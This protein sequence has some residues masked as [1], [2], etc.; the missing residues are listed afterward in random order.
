M[1]HEDQQARTQEFL[2]RCSQD[3]NQ[4]YREI[5]RQQYHFSP[6]GTTREF[7]DYA[8]DLAEVMVLELKMFRTSAEERR[9]RRL[10]SSG[11]DDL[12]AQIGTKIVFGGIYVQI[13]H[14]RCI[15]LSRLLHSPLK[16][17]SSADDAAGA[18]GNA[19]R[20]DTNR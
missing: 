3:R 17:R 19:S 14:H 7:E 1:F 9:V 11:S 12:E 6:P 16:C 5:V 13:T 4:S 8:V 10:P 15:S 2:L 20:S 18:L